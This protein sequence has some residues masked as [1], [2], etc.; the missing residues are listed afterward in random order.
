M[1][2]AR[3]APVTF[4]ANT[5]RH[6]VRMGDATTTRRR[7]RTV[8][9]PDLT[10][11]TDGPVT[12]CGKTWR[13]DLESAL[14]CEKAAHGLAKQ[15][16]ALVRKQLDDAT[17]EILR[18]RESDRA[19]RR[20]VVALRTNLEASR[21]RVDELEVRVDK[22]ES[23]RD[24][25]ADQIA[26]AD[27]QV[28]DLRARETAT[29]ERI[30]DLER[31]LSAAR[32]T[33]TG[34]RDERD[35]ALRE[36]HRTKD[37]L[38][39]TVDARSR[40]EAGR[41][42]AERQN[43]SLLVLLAGAHAVVASMQMSMTRTEEIAREQD[44]VATQAKLSLAEQVRDAQRQVVTLREAGHALAT[45]LATA[46]TEAERT[47]S[48]RDASREDVQRANARVAELHQSLDDSATNLTAS[49][50]RELEL[51]ALRDK[52]I[53]ESRE[54]TRRA[55]TDET[56]FVQTCG[57]QAERIRVLKGEL[58]DATHRYDTLMAR[59]AL[60]ET[61]AADQDETVDR[62]RTDLANRDADILALI[63]ESE[64]R[65]NAFRTELVDAARHAKE[66]SDTL[67]AQIEDLGGQ[68]ETQAAELVSRVRERD[69]IA[70]R[71]LERKQ[72]EWQVEKAN[73]NE[74]LRAA[75]SHNASRDEMMRI[76]LGRI[77]QLEALVARHAESAGAGADADVLAK[78]NEAVAEKTDA[79]DKK[80]REY[81]V[82]VAELTQA[83][84]S[85]GTLADQL[86]CMTC[87]KSRLEHLADDYRKRYEELEET[88]AAKDQQVTELQTDL[89]RIRREQPTV[90][91][92]RTAHETAVSI[93]NSKLAETET[94][95]AKAQN[96]LHTAHETVDRLT[97]R[98]AALTS[99]QSS[100]QT[101]AAT[102]TDLRAKNEKA[103][104]EVIAT[105][106]K[107]YELERKLKDANREQ[108]RVAEL[109][110]A[111]RLAEEDWQAQKAAN[112]E[113]H[114][115]LTKI[116]S[117]Q[118]GT[119]ATPKVPARGRR[120][121][122]PFA[123]F[124]PATHTT[125]FDG[126]AD[127]A[128][129][130]DIASPT[131]QGQGHARGSALVG[132]AREIVAGVAGVADLAMGV[133]G[134]A[135]SSLLTMVARRVMH[136]SRAETTGRERESDLSGPDSDAEVDRVPLQADPET[137][138]EIPTH[139]P[140]DRRG[141]VDHLSDDATKHASPAPIAPVAPV[142]AP[143]R[144]H[145]ATSTAHAPVPNARA[146]AKRRYDDLARAPPPPAKRPVLTIDPIDSV[147]WAQRKTNDC[148]EKADQR[149][150]DARAL[151]KELDE[152]TAR[153]QR[154]RKAW[155]PT[156]PSNGPVSDRDGHGDGRPRRAV[157][158]DTAFVP[159]PSDSA[160]HAPANGDGDGDGEV[161]SRPPPRRGGGSR[162]VLIA[163]VLAQ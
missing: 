163:S 51:T 7:S 83:R 77:Q 93:L 23:E 49:K 30:A 159:R 143:R 142:A 13:V 64:R 12:R 87:D 32:S 96:A 132:S 162:S 91:S 113:M 20:D 109:E 31:L 121:R 63:E 107:L 127:F 123:M 86:R 76:Q 75:A 22:A 105:Q 19:L 11:P 60:I 15:R 4:F 88:V 81:E 52:V 1:R 99:E 6:A 150:A 136:R 29:A 78:A 33:A 108:G 56:L 92:E 57:E 94:R 120:R 154:Q 97:E 2:T 46:E 126:D 42:R 68:L 69:T 50:A 101:N 9:E 58:A 43:R 133:T 8:A 156:L 118:A 48:E 82:K 103:H 16:L 161:S 119:D 160:Y 141:S 148:Q 146:S 66:T 37:E 18:S 55:E 47:T 152:W 131:A 54:R 114:A 116:R 10:D 85:N 5:S 74:S 17:D 102:I 128:S 40:A 98:V 65:E 84:D 95:C 147:R 149:A 129:G 41:D 117:G 89:E 44:R 100:V 59:L 111:L 35:A 28:S 71:H 38:Q 135:A 122:W 79:L 155:E 144:S 14:S 112:E 73:L 27:A 90:L 34:L 80:H 21:G 153:R 157:S 104:Q 26:R 36:L 3:T 139:A 125:N 138:S 72:Q 140:V 106:R 134:T 137:E 53:E 61:H 110:R 151:Q 39:R 130:S 45:S 24:A 67:Y 124:A 25:L 145:A 70:Q 115:F 158:D 62:L